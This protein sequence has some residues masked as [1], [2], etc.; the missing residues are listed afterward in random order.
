MCINC[1]FKV[2]GTSLF[3]LRTLGN[4]YKIPSVHN[5][6]SNERKQSLA[7]ERKFSNAETQIKNG[8]F[9]DTG[10]LIEIKEKSNNAPEVVK[11]INPSHKQTLSACSSKGTI[12]RKCKIKFVNKI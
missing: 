1:H 10:E 3:K 2:D 8:R 7:D 5:I 9:H 4:H 11:L 12:L 6:L